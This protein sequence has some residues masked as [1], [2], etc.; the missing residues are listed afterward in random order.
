MFNKCTKLLVLNMKN[1]VEWRK[2]SSNDTAIPYM[3]EEVKRGHWGWVKYTASK[4]YVS[5]KQ[6]CYS[7]GY[8]SFL[9]ALKLGYVSSQTVKQ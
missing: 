8:L 5:D 7:K 1:K 3:F 9:K 4:C 2:E 6:D